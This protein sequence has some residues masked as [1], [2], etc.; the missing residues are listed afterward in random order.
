MASN[1]QRELETVAHLV[2][3]TTENLDKMVNSTKGIAKNFSEFGQQLRGHNRSMRETLLSTINL[4]KW[5]Q[6]GSQALV[7]PIEEMNTALAASRDK[8]A[9]A[10]SEL[11]KQQKQL[12]Q[13]TTTYTGIF[14]HQQKAVD[15]AKQAVNQ[16]EKEV[17]F[18]EKLLSFKQ[19][20]AKWSGVEMA[21]EAAVAKG[22]ADAIRRSGAL[23]QSLIEANSATSVRAQLS[24]DVWEVMAKTGNA[25]AEMLAAAKALTGVGFDLRKNFKDTLEVMVEM[26]EGLGVSYENSAQLARIFEVSLKTP[27]REVADQIAAIANQT[28]LMADEATRYAV[29]IGKALRL[30]GPLEGNTS[31]ATGY[32]AMMAG[33][34]KDVG[35]NAEDVVKMFG[36]MTKGTAQGFMLRGLA[37]VGAPGTLRTQAG[38]QQAMEGI[39]RIIK[40]IVSA[41]PGSAAYTA[42]LETA[43]QMF[44]TSAE[45]ITYWRDMMAKANEPLNE[46]QKLQARWQEQIANANKS[47]GLIK[48][49]LFALIQRGLTPWIEY[50]SI[51]LKWIA[52][53]V[54]SIAENKYAMWAAAVILPAVIGKAVWSLRA[55]Y[56]ALKQVAKNA[57]AA[58]IAEAARGGLGGVGGLPKSLAA[59]AAYGKAIQGFSGFV[60]KWTGFSLL[61]KTVAA[62]LPKVSGFLGNWL[63]KMFQTQYSG[64][65]GLGKLNTLTSGLNTRIWGLVGRLGV[66]GP[67][68]AVAAAWAASHAVGRWYDKKFPGNWIAALSEK[69]GEAWYAKA[70]AKS[71]AIVGKSREGTKS[72]QEVAAE[73]RQAIYTGKEDTIQSI[74]EQNIGKVRGLTTEAA[75]AAYK[76]IVLP[77]TAEA[78]ERMGLASVTSA[79]AQTA[80]KDRKSIELSKQ[81]V[82]AQ[83]SIKDTLAKANADRKQ[84]EAQRRRDEFIIAFQ[85]TTH[86]KLMVNPGTNTKTSASMWAISP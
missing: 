73:I 50:L 66:M 77:A 55:L 11:D 47:L 21:L 25:Q 26:E 13:F 49:S 29:E 18:A 82:G 36:E 9:G 86:R 59:Q 6:I 1:E 54:S 78:R 74:W 61:S 38:A 67:V 28:S 44:G 30:L 79:E 68:A 62:H 85:E 69:I 2:R 31:K 56:L 52:K 37:G 4:P 53:I 45:A 42:Q 8:L 70:N 65:L 51:A 33:R 35:G 5:M 57:T 22:F 32:V 72:W 23:N 64:V 84:E 12:N 48:N 10:T 19:Q 27:V 80:E 17:A 60:S 24:R 40:S 34:M 46:Q 39:D 41:A 3:M 71:A 58:S 83:L 75:A 14:P 16:A 81:G 43:A 15:M 63:P 76:A 20:Y 7:T